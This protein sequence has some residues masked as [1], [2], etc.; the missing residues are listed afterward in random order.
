MK[1]I[2]IS[3]ITASYNYAN[4]ISETINSVISQTYS[5][6]ELIIVDDG[7]RDNSVQIIEEF[8]KKDERIKF[9]QHEADCGQMVKI[10]EGMGDNSN[11]GGLNKGLKETILLGLQKCEGD[12]IAFLES[13]D[14]WTKNY[15]AEKI[16]II[17]NYPQAKIIFNDVELFGDSGVIADYDKYFKLNKKILGSKK[18]PTNLFDGFS[19]QNLIPT[20]S[21][22]MVESKTLK[23][24][25]FDSSVE[26]FLDHWLWAHLAYENEFYYL[27][28]KLTLWRMH[29]KSYIEQ[30]QQNNEK[31]FLASI[32][33]SLENTGAKKNMFFWRRHKHPKIEKLF[34]GFFRLFV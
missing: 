11:K 6:W 10:P 28:K 25:N 2:K 18:Y 4:F 5:N 1:N 15:L 19:F 34:R 17:E 16:E 24:A 23:S 31:T 26:A 13:D 7:S 9:F 32:L 20:F 30:K 22:V 33:K 21:C 14:I 12:Y 29:K 3:V 8:C 27:D